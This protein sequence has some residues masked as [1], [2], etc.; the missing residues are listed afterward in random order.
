MLS[1]QCGASAF[2][3]PVTIV[4][5]VQREI[6]RPVERLV[7][8]QEKRC[9]EAD[10]N[11]LVLCLNKVV[12]WVFTTVVKIIENV[13]EIVLVQVVRV[14]CRI[15][16]EVV[17]LAINLGR[18][19]GNLI[20][21]IL[22][23]NPERIL[24]G[25]RFFLDGIS[26]FVWGVARIA[27]NVVGTVLGVVSVVPATIVGRLIGKDLLNG[28]PPS[29]NAPE[30]AK[31]NLTSDPGTYKRL[32]DAAKFWGFVSTPLFKES[33]IR[34]WTNYDLRACATGTVLH[35]ASSTDGFYT[36]DLEIDTSA[37][38]NTIF[39]MII[40]PGKWRTK[41]DQRSQMPFMK[42]CSEVLMETLLWNLI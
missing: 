37:S 11:W 39:D 1:V 22:T 34:G 7:E 3:A 25:L 31:A 23:L 6:V 38:W 5:W 2:L 12:C 17:N 8:T 40:S 27:L 19:I 10:C 24:R 36:V 20:A 14:V 41:M 29:I 42:N 32:S 18:G 21:G 26:G 15:V 9:R 35:T 30:E 28:D 4:D 33:G 13:V 16:C